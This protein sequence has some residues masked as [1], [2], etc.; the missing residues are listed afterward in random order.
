MG[1]DYVDVESN[2]L[3]SKLRGAVASPI[4]IAELDLDVLAFRIPECMQSAP[5]SIG[6][7]VRR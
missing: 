2:E 7:R 1:D 5:E 3:F 4:G 6:K